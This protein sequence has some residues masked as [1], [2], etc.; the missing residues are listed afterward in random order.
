MDEYKE[1]VLTG[2]GRCSSDLWALQALSRV[3]KRLVTKSEI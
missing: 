3:H 2:R 1:L